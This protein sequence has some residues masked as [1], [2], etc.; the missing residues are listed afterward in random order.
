M[1]NI[2]L[3]LTAADLNYHNYVE[4]QKSEN[5]ENGPFTLRLRKD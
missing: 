3:G 1:F 5:V 2:V 4:Y